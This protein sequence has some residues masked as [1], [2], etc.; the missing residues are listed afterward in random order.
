MI[1]LDTYTDQIMEVSTSGGR[2]IV[3]ETPIDSRTQCDQEQAS[4]M[5]LDDFTRYFPVYS[6]WWL[7]NLLLGV[8][9]VASLCST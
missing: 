1:L 5:A 2:A 7:S 4:Y 3:P 6:N 9:C 8:T